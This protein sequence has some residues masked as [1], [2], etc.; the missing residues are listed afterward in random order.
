[1][2]KDVP[3]Q[4]V[5]YLVSCLQPDCIHPVCK[6]NEIT[7]VP[8]WYS[9]GPLITYIPFPV[10]DPSRPRGTPDCQS[11]KGECGRHY[12]QPS[13]AL[14]SQEKAVKQPPS[15]FLKESFQSKKRVS[16]LS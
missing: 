1:M 3:F 7:D 13:A 11:C 8:R 14:L 4:Y 2:A 16:F 12:L 15:S 6:N 5:F 9:N 10:V